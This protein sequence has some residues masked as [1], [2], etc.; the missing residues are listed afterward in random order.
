MTFAFAAAGDTNL[1]WQ[2]DILDAANFLSGGRF[3]SGLP[4]SWNAGDFTFDGV[5]DILDAAALISTGLFDSGAYNS[6]TARLAAVPEPVGGSAWWAAA[7]CSWL[8]LRR[9][10]TSPTATDEPARLPTR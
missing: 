2:I 4:A 10:R 9:H 7:A 5:T 6:P 1:D 8:V 3:D